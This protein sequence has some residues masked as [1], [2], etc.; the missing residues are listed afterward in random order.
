MGHDQSRHSSAWAERSRPEREL[1]VL[2]DRDSV[3]E[4]PDSLLNLV[5]RRDDVFSASYLASGP[6][7][8]QPMF[9]ADLFLARPIP[10]RWVVF[11]PP[12]PDST[13]PAITVLAAC[14]DHVRTGSLWPGQ[15]EALVQAVTERG[16]SLEPTDAILLQIATALEIDVIVTA[17]TNLLAL[18][19]WDDD[20]EIVA[21]P[22]A[23]AV[24]SLYQR[25]CSNLYLAIG[26]G[27]DD[28]ASPA[29]FYFNRVLDEHIESL[30]AVDASIDAHGTREEIE[31]F[32]ACR[33][34]LSAALLHRDRVRRL[35]LLHP[36]AA[37]VDELS[38]EVDMV[39]LFLTSAFDAVARM[40]DRRL[41]LM[42][43]RMK[44]GF[45]KADWRN[46]IN[47]RTGIEFDA[48]TTNVIEAVTGLRNVIHS[49][50]ARAVPVNEGDG[51]NARTR[52]HVL[53]EHAQESG[54]WTRP[55][56]AVA[57]LFKSGFFARSLLLRRLHPSQDVLIPAFPLCDTL[58]SG[59]LQVLDKVFSSLLKTAEFPAG[60]VIEER[61]LFYPHVLR[62]QT[63]AFIALPGFVPPMDEPGIAGC[64][65]PAS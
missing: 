21:V 43:P 65:R 38:A 6:P 32:A 55:L 53:Y 63:R 48:I 16:Y 3:D 35:G 22:D 39:L 19:P 44:I 50:G 26:P 12:T 29:S 58:I 7:D 62:A 2:V 15:T 47:T 5:L 34:K 8:D 33:R 40:I 28:S 14:D 17:R 37:E 45:Q 13:T 25:A 27:R 23:I 36:T 42:T 51:F 24:V 59:T 61:Q 10:L 46:T 52:T 9:E 60:L 49:T 18:E 41:G 54:N 56:D 31:L 57:G 30:A 1:R 4:H 11:E 20:L 64:E